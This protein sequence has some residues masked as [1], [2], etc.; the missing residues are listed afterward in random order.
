[1]TAKH[2]PAPRNVPLPPDGYWFFVRPSCEACG[3]ARRSPLGL[4]C[5]YNQCFARVHPLGRCDN[6]EPLP[7]YRCH[8]H[9][10]FTEPT[11]GHL[12]RC[13]VVHDDGPR[14]LQCPTCLK[15]CRPI[16]DA[17]VPSSPIPK[18]GKE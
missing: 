8:E 10:T 11:G 14:C 6:F 15:W 12:K 18:T 3:H 4:A 7:F 9:G 16:T 2:K 1:M 17:T 13:A 5:S